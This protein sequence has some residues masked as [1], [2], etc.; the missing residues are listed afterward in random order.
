MDIDLSSAAS[1]TVNFFDRSL[2]TSA[3]AWDDGVAVATGT[4]GGIDITLGS[5]S[6]I[7]AGS[8]VRLDLG[9]NADFGFSG[10]AKI[11]N[12]PS[13]GS[14][15]VQVATYDSTSAMLDKGKTFV[16][17]IDPVAVNMTMPKVRGNG[18]PT[19]TLES[20]TVMTIMSLTTNYEA[21][22]RYASASSTAWQDM[23]QLFFT[24][25]G[26]YHTVLLTGLMSAM[27]YT[28]YVRCRERVTLIR[29]TTDYVIDFYIAA[30]G[31][32]TGGG[33]GGGT[34]TGTGGGNAGGSSSGGSG[35]G[36]GSGSG[37]FKPFPLD[38]P[39]P[40]DVTFSGWAYPS[41]LI[42]VLQ[43]DKK[44]GE[45][46]ASVDGSFLFAV[47]EISKGLYTFILRARDTDG[48]RSSAYTSTFWIEENT[49]TNISNILMSPTIK[50]DSDYVDLGASIRSFG[51][52]IPGKKVELSVYSPASKKTMATLE[53]RAGADG[54]WTIT[55]ST[56]DYPRGA[57]DFKARA[58][59]DTLG[60]SLYGETVKCGVGER[61]AAE[62]TPCARSDV[63][64]DGKVNLI[65]FS[66][67]MFYWGSTNATADINKDGKVNLVDFSIMMYCWTG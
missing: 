29:D 47:P 21:D 52:S 63:N 37:V 6:G 19:G 3:S 33:E 65:D 44:A 8:Q 43:D 13:K 48:A 35:G 9:T 5:L 62:E 1:G 7:A 53:T 20:H 38:R 59:H 23:T 17:M 24:A 40:P 11:V 16:V 54:R 14:Y 46:S 15:P 66:I 27:H 18:L 55:V 42:S 2:A 45:V 4:G 10:D 51:Q 32:G 58:F 67:L 30:R 25:D 50:L 60:W 61:L 41:S 12:A 34:G 49:Q 39:S 22:C 56:A 64:K 31:T 36:G 28:Y 57:Y 26:V